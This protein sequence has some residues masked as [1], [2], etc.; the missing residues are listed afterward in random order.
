V[1]RVLQ[2]AGNANAL[3]YRDAD[4]L[5]NRRRHEAIPANQAPS[6]S[7]VWS[8]PGRVTCVSSNSVT[9]ITPGAGSSTTSTTTVSTAGVGG[10]IR[11]SFFRAAFFA[12][13]R[14]GL[15]LAI[16]CFVPPARCLDALRVLLRAAELPLRTFARFFG[17]TV[18]RFFR[19]A[20]IDPSR[21][22]H[23]ADP[24][25][26]HY[27]HKQ[28]GCGFKDAPA[29]R[30]VEKA[31][32]PSCAGAVLQPTYSARFCSSASFSVLGAAGS[33]STVAL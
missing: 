8:E 21:L 3:S 10:F 14:L 32:G 31:P 23:C 24:A 20:M 7:S 11:C 29:L 5:G 30:A 28:L 13:A 12:P 27:K 9:V 15:A 6:S 33:C 16:V 19:L 26:G 22:L 25:L 18:D 1:G 17:C 2:Q 4:G